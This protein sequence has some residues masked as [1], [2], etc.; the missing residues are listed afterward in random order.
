MPGETKK[1][2]SYSADKKKWEPTPIFN[3]NGMCDGTL[4]K[5][6]TVRGVTVGNL[7]NGDV[8]KEGM[9]FTQF[10]EKLLVKQIPYNYVKPTISLSSNTELK[11]ERGTTITPT[12]S[13]QYNKHDGGDVLTYKLT[14][15]I[16]KNTTEALDDVVIRDHT[17]EIILNDNVQFKAEV[18]YADGPIKQ[19]NLGQDQPEGQIK[20]NKITSSITISAVKAYWGFPSDSETEPTAEEI[21]DTDVT[22][23]DLQKGSTIKVVAKPSTRTIVFAYPATLGDC[24]KIRYED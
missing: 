17:E 2:L 11:F 5:D 4:E 20:R 16:L 19:N 22:G 10:V 9:T 3:S 7:K 12:I 6:I 13:C 18:E 14:K 23:I 15:K 1:T 24:T 21:R 8:L